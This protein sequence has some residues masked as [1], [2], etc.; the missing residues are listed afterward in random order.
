MTSST[1]VKDE[2]EKFDRCVERVLTGVGKAGV[3]GGALGFLIGLR[4]PYLG[5]TIFG[6]SIGAGFGSSC[7]ECE[8]DFQGRIRY[9]RPKTADARSSVAVVAEAPS[10]LPSTPVVE[11]VTVTVD[12]VEQSSADQIASLVE[13]ALNTGNDEE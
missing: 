10:V 4:R 11:E 7:K 8:F 6:L 2:F 12:A 13:A 1:G 3:V 5:T 9:F